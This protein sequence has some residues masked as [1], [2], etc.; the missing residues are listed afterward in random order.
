MNMGIQ[1]KYFLKD[2]CVS[3]GVCVKKEWVPK[4]TLPLEERSVDK[5]GL[6]ERW[7]GII[8][9]GEG[10]QDEVH[11]GVVKGA[12]H[13]LGHSGEEVVGELVRRV[14]GFLEGLPEKGF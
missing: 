13:N 12:S 11:S 3:T 5:E 9:R 4:E 1:M 7:T 6:I 14:V 10:R 8:K 2:V